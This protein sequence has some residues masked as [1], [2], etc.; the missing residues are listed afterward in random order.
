MRALR[1]AMY[2][3]RLTRS[4]RP[5]KAMLSISIFSSV[6]NIDLS[7]YLDPQIT[8]SHRGPRAE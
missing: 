6:S 3:A 7:V 1:I 2:F 8:E 5:G 4:M